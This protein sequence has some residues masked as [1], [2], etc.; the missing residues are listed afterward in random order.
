MLAIA[1]QTAGDNSEKQ[2]L[3]AKIK[4]KNLDSAVRKTPKSLV[5]L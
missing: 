1:G 5:L 4:R 3:K 2:R